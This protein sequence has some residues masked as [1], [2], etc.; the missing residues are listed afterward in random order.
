MKKSIYILTL[1]LITFFSCS[2]DDD[3]NEE[4]QINQAHIVE[5]TTGTLNGSVSVILTTTLNFE[6]ITQD[7]VISDFDYNNNIVSVEIP[8]DTASFELEFYIEDS[9]SANMKF[10]G[11]EDNQVIH[12]ETTSGQVYQYSYSFN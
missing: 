7:E 6:D 5:F 11:A 10:Y 4:Q 9:S 3:S 12:Q 2:S 1:L 8:E